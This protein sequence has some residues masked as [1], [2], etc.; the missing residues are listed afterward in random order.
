MNNNQ[1]KFAT[2]DL[3]LGIAVNDI[4]DGDKILGHVDDDEVLLVRCGAEFLAVGAHC[5][6]YHGPLAE[7]TRGR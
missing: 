5:T 2:P 1:S 6:H 4:A 7:G 3:K